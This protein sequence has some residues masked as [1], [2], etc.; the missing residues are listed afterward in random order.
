MKNE[1]WCKIKEYLAKELNGKSKDANMILDDGDVEIQLQ[2]QLDIKKINKL[3]R[4]Q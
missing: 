3:R 2:S 1:S 4:A